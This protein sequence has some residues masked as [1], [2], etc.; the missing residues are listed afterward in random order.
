MEIGQNLKTSGGE[1][2]CSLRVTESLEQK[3]GL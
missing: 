2:D 1:S 3:I